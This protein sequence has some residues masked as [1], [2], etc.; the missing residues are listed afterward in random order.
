[1]ESMAVSKSSVI[2]KTLEIDLSLP[3]ISGP[4]HLPIDSKGIKVEGEGEWIRRKHGASSRRIWRKVH[5]GIDAGS[6][7]IRAAKVTKSSVGDGPVL[8]DL[9]NQISESQ[10]VAFV[11]AYGA[12]DTRVCRD[13]IADRRAN[14]IITPAMKMNQYLMA[15]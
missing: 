2:M 11:N 12:Y 4:L 7:D 8:P 10:E 15:A 14:A 5:I 3:A 6:L 13:A 1:M 9:L